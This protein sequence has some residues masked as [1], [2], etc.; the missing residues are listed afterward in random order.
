M[1]ELLNQ[2]QELESML[3]EEYK[4]GFSTDVEYEEFPIGLNEDIIREL[5][6]R[7]GEPEW[8]LEFRLKAYRAWLE[9]EE[10]D[11][12]NATYEKPKFNELQYYSAPKNRPKY[13][14]LDEVDPSIL[15]TYE[16]LGIPL[17][18]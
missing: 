6:A 4:Y 13:D 10:P 7:K 12:F 8:M 11:W 5:S 1:S 16:K 3:A 9:M 17:E 15:E 2:T 18:E 14:S